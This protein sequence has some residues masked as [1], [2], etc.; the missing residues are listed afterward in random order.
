MFEDPQT[1][2][3][4]AIVKPL[5]CIVG[6]AEDYTTLKPIAPYQART[7]RQRDAIKEVILGECPAVLT[8][9]PWVTRLKPFDM[10]KALK[11]ILDMP[12]LSEKIRAVKIGYVPPLLEA[13]THTRYFRALLHMEE[14]QSA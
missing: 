13:N 12:I 3:R 4:F 2:T 11:A 10:P 9:V 14:Q 7:R 6:D 5:M 8:T 1:Q